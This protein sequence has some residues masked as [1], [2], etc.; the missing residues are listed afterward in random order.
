MAVSSSFSASSMTM[1]QRPAGTSTACRYSLQAKS[2][3]SVERLGV[4]D[5][6]LALPSASRHRR[7]Q[8]VEGLRALPVHIR[9]L[10]GMADLASGRVAVSDFRELDLEDLLGRDPVPPNPA[11]LARD[12]AGKT[13]LVTGAG[14]SIGSELCRQILVER[15]AKLLLVEH[16]EFALYGI[17][18]ELEALVASLAPFDASGH[19]PEPPELIGLLGNVRDYERISEIFRA[20]RPDTVYHAAAY[21]H[22]PIV[23][24]NLCEGLSNNVFG[25]LNVARA[26]MESGAA[27]FVLVSTDKAVRPTNV[28]GASKRIAE[29]ILQA[30][31]AETMVRFDDEFTRCRARAQPHALCHGEVRQCAGVQRQRR[32]P[33]S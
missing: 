4:S 22:V 20:Y 1:L 8:I 25:T 32:S 19:Q 17:H 13:V 28:M 2:P 12:L 14:G 6:L 23:E 16:S 9:T 27:S 26:A 7:H 3:K 33:V 30:L 11:L 10:P 24:H 31:A 29:M 15:P 21:K 18:Q 5:I